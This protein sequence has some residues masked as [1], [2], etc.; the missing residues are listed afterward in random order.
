MREEG[1]MFLSSLIPRSTI[2]EIAESL[3]RDK[4]GE[5]RVNQE[6]LSDYNSSDQKWESNTQNLHYLSP[7]V[8][9]KSSSESTY[10]HTEIG[11]DRDKYFEGQQV[12][13]SEK[14]KIA[15]YSIQHGTKA[16]LLK[17]PFSKASVRTWRKE[18]AYYGYHPIHPKW[19]EPHAGVQNLLGKDKYTPENRLKLVRKALDRKEQT[20]K[21]FAEGN[22]ISCSTLRYY[23][24]T[25]KKF[26]SQAEI[27]NSNVVNHSKN[28]D[29]SQK[30]NIVSE[31]FLNP[32]KDVCLKYQIRNYVLSDWKNKYFTYNI[33]NCNWVAPQKEKIL[34]FERNEMEIHNK[35]EE[36]RIKNAKWK[37]L[38]DNLGENVNKSDLERKE[39]SWSGEEE[40]NDCKGKGE[41][42]SIFVSELKSVVYALLHSD[43]EAY[44]IYKLPNKKLKEM[45]YQFLYNGYYKLHPP[46]ESQS[47][48]PSNSNRI[49]KDSPRVEANDGTTNKR[50]NK[51]RQIPPSERLKIVKKYINRGEK[52]SIAEFGRRVGVSRAALKKWEAVYNN[53][54]EEAQLFT[55]QF[56]K[57]H[58]D[59]SINEKISIVQE[60]FE[61]SSYDAVA[62]CYGITRPVIDRWKK[63]Y[64]TRG[65]VNKD[66]DHHHI[67]ELETD[68]Y[69]ESLGDKKG[70]TG[71]VKHKDI[72]SSKNSENAFEHLELTPKS[73]EL[74]N[75][76]PH[77]DNNSELNELLE[78]LTNSIEFLD[79]ISPNTLG[80]D[81]SKYNSSIL[82]RNIPLKENKRSSSNRIDKGIL[83]D[84]VNDDLEL[85]NKLSF[86]YSKE[87]SLTKGKI[88]KYK[89][90]LKKLELAESQNS[91]Y[92]PLDSIKLQKRMKIDE[93]RKDIANMNPRS[94]NGYRI[95][96][97]KI[98]KHFYDPGRRLRITQKALSCGPK[99]LT[100][101]AQKVGIGK[102]S[103]DA[104]IK[105]YEL[106]GANALIFTT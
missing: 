83:Q 28:F 27:F 73:M 67:A 5:S 54:G 105:Q 81:K 30:I 29:L 65:N 95:K 66:K 17:Y 90:E 84:S 7:T 82:T 103:L 98:H 92:K 37:A 14:L 74:E 6:Y 36:N 39:N 94:K 24:N 51:Y 1:K 77:I 55:E 34:E 64:F 52:E 40:R 11:K 70:G 26:G 69:L 72:I 8:T 42:V 75:L 18:F 31:S 22:G 48:I 23:I 3:P 20:F 71:T 50:C 43:E 97:K 35:L 32:L 85:I 86:D 106:Y 46:N 78:E 104:W 9:E 101:Y 76:H 89:N 13:F 99:S 12:K 2:K 56:P 58:K 57:Y 19:K 80:R 61:S 47:T 102:V 33:H 59:F 79:E 62:G 45:K 68:K 4:R 87:I 44:E 15:I 91:L 88:K 16:A 25:Y 10:T 60:A 96:A 38:T 100:R 93:E 21:S 63:L 53:K 49:I 41:S